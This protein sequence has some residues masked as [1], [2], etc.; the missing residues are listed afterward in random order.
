[1]PTEEF[2]PYQSPQSPPEM[3]LRERP[4]PS[5]AAVLMFVVAAIPVGMI[6]FGFAAGLVLAIGGEALGGLAVLCGFAAM[7][8]AILGLGYFTIIKLM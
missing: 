2:N 3:R 1:M 7:G 4:M 5:F 6:T 8:L